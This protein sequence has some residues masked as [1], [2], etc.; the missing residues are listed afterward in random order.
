MHFHAQKYN[1]LELAK[2]KKTF[3]KEYSRSTIPILYN[4]STKAT[5]LYSPYDKYLNIYFL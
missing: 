4:F 3:I 1:L 5:I 2:Y